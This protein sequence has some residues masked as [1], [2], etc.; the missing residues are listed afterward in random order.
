MAARRP[1]RAELAFLLLFHAALSGAFLVAWLTGD[2]D[3]YGM[4]LFA[5]YAVLAALAARLGAALLAPAG[6]PLALPQP[7]LRRAPAGRNLLY[8]W[9]AAAMLAFT[10][11]VAVSGWI[12]DRLP[13]LE[14][15]H[16]AIAELAPA[17][18]LAHVALVLVLHGLGRPRRVAG[19]AAVRV[20]VLVLGLA[21]L[22][23]AALAAG[24]GDP[25]RD[26]I[27]ATYEAAARAADPGFKGFSAAR[28]E[29]LYQGPHEGGDNPEIRACASC[30]TPDPRREG[31]HARTGRAI[32][33]MAVSANPKRF[34][35]A[36]E[37]EKR[38]ARDCKNVMGR[39]C[40][41]Q[42]KGDYVTFLAGR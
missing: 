42:E 41:P 38:F 27:L 18:I 22:A 5:G 35:D 3:L 31:Q 40:T 25:R 32:L 1:T 21:V 29:A 37:V 33:P 8:A 17:V 24:S 6:S 28:G 14:D 39:A 20:A 10:A 11:L 7:R 13:R 30:H 15:L 26:T 19:T 36:A 9:M 2:E 16:E 34:T 4:H 12:A 23:G